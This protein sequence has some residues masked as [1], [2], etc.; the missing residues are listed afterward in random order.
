MCRLYTKQILS[1][2]PSP[3]VRCS[4]SVHAWFCTLLSRTIKRHIISPNVLNRVHFGFVVFESQ[5]DGA[6]MEPILR[7]TPQKSLQHILESVV[8]HAQ[9]P[10]LGSIVP[11]R[12]SMAHS[13]L[14]LLFYCCN[15]LLL[16][17]I[18][19]SGSIFPAYPQR[20]R[21]ERYT[22][23]PAYDLPYALSISILSLAISCTA[24]MRR[25]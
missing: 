8:S 10:V 3:F 16:P 17:L 24:K 18:S 14:L 2:S 6:P 4:S 23:T 25:A 5:C 9:N 15:L 19:S 1:C 21:G 11:Y 22:S 20:Q 7:K 13:L 12:L